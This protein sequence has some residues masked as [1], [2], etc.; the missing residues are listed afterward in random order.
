VSW[1]DAQAYCAWLGEQTGEVYALPTEAQWEH[2]C[3][4][5]TSTH[6]CHGDD[7]AG[8]SEYAWYSANAEG[9]LHPVAAKRP[10]AWDLYD[11]HGNVWEWCEDWYAGDYYRQLASVG[12]HAASNTGESAST[13]SRPASENP[14]GPGEG[15]YRVV[16]GGSWS[17]DAGLCRSASRYNHEPSYR[18]DYLGFRLARQV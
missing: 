17:S 5:G 9:R 3:R 16:R 7:E 11:L 2:A 4:A 12:E 10:N 1:P 14:R 8:L 18:L 15:F 6:W 13:A